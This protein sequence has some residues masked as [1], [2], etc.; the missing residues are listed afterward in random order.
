[1]DTEDFN[2][3]VEH[4]LKQCEKT[5][6]TKAVE[7][8]TEDR[9]HNFKVAATLAGCTPAQALG[10]MM[11][12]HTVSIYDMIADDGTIEHPMEVWSEKITDH[13]NYLL[14]LSA[15]LQ[16]EESMKEDAKFENSTPKPEGQP[17]A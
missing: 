11:I 5:L 17:S 16:E 7:Y 6:V 10:G 14:L 1:M 15:I 9:L 13:L 4:Q 12:K 8:A 2:F 3:I